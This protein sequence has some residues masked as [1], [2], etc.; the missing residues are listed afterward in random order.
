MHECLNVVAYSG[1]AAGAVLIRAIAPVVGVDEIR[2]RRG[3]PTDPTD[4]LCSGPAK[5]CQGLAV[6]RSLNGHDLTQGEGLW[7]ARTDGEPVG[8]IA[9]GPRVGVAYAGEWAS[10][11]WRFWLAGNRAVSRK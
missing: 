11:P 7:L 3:R 8:E 10:K 6:D 1:A 2:Q 5:V 9:S 4:R